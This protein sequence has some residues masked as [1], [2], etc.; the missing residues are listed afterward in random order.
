MAIPI[1]VNGRAPTNN[2]TTSW[3]IVPLE[4]VTS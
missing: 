2:T 1:A 3:G 4:N